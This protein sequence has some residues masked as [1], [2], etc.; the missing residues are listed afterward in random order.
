MPHFILTLVHIFRT[1]FDFQK[2]DIR[3]DKI[4]DLQ[5]VQVLPAEDVG[6]TGEINYKLNDKFMFSK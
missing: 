1:F 3:K 4:A 2:S 6:G 5:K